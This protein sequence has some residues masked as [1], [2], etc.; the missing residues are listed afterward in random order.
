MRKDAPLAVDIPSPERDKPA[1]VKVGVIAA[2]GF[3]IGVAWPRVAG[4]RFGPSAPGEASANASATAAAPRAPDAPPASVK[5]TTALPVATTPPA[6]K[7]PPPPPQVTVARGIVVTCKTTDG[8]AKKGKECG[9]INGLEGLVQPRLKKISACAGVEGV[10]GKFSFVANADFARGS[11]SYEIAK[12][13]TVTNADAVNACLKTTFHGVTPAG[14]PHEHARYSVS[15][16]VT[17]APGIEAAP[18]PATAA[19]NTPAPEPA[20]AKPDEPKPEAPA[21]GEAAVAWDVALVRDVPKNGQVVARLQR[22]TKVKIGTMKD[23]WYSVKYGDD[24]KSD[25]WV[26]R[27]AI[28]R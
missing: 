13:S 6:P 16:G 2:V 23:G 3:V 4:V 26:Y 9:S 20:A 5:A 24:W 22:G 7:A 11:L 28:G 18:P 12:G 27:A 17:L 21:A 15:Y 14:I 1:W 25:G 8:E 19:V 10:T